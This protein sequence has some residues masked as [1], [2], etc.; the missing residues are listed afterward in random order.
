MDMVVN[1]IELGGLRSAPKAI[2]EPVV[3]GKDILELFAGAMYADPLSIYREYIQNAADSLDAAREAGQ[4]SNAPADVDVWFDQAERTVRIRDLGAGVP[5]AQFNRRL[6]SIGASSKRGTQAR[7]FRGI[8]RLSGLGYCQ[9]LVFRSRAKGDAKVKEMVWN[10][11]ALRER[12]RSADYRGSLGDLITEIAAVREL[13]G[14]EYPAH[15]FEV[16]LRKLLRVKNDILLNEEAVRLYLSQV[17]PVPFSPDFELGAEI[18]AWL[19]ERICSEPIRIMIHDG[20]GLL[21][22]RAVN[23]FPVSPKVL[24]TFR[25]V[26][27]REYKDSDGVVLAYGWTLDHA[28]VGS[29][30]RKLGLGGIR[31]RSGNVQV[32]DDEAAAFAFPETRFTRWVVGDVHVVHPKI[33]PNGRRDDFEHSPALGQLGEQLRDLAK[34]LTATIRERSEQRTK[35]KKVQL[36][37]QYG[38]EWHRESVGASAVA[39]A[40]AATD[41]ATHFAAEAERALGKLRESVPGREQ[42]GTLVATFREELDRWSK[43]NVRRFA[44]VNPMQRAA[45]VAVLS[46]SV[47]SQAVMPLALDVLRAMKKSAG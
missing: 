36:A 35:L 4:M 40:A 33:I 41:R 26:D 21:Y 3:V 20:R 9:E 23:A 38:E 11:R 31:M 44:A 30:S 8:G 12:L 5:G 27:Y 42:A 32:G 22:H 46:S 45:L 29:I 19:T 1:R 37:L 13:P 10:G 6:T 18:Q 34:A 14:A 25:G 7:G 24:D 16:E 2:T 43:N 15:F 47:K 28:Y 17:A 39:L